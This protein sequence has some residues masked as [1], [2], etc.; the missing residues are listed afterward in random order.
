MHNSDEKHTPGARWPFYLAILV[1]VASLI[2]FWQSPHL[3]LWIGQSIAWAGDPASIESFVIWLGWLGPPVLIGLHALQIVVAPLPAYALFGAAG[4]LYGPV[5]G[6]IYATLGTLL[7]ASAAMLL[8]RHFGYPLAA[9][10]VGAD[11]L[12]R[13]HDRALNQSWITWGF[14]LLAPIGDLPY[15]LAGLAGISLWRI[16]VLTLVIRVPSIFLIA[17]AASGSTA[18]S[19]QEVIPLMGVVI[20]L[21]ALLFRYQTALQQWLDRLTQQRFTPENEHKLP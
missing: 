17:A 1:V 2:G 18:L 8:T 16:L 15:F 14:L 10:M 5:W 4:F 21:C 12:T 3:R 11:R 13:W 6:G 20:I 19:W 9:R 7:G